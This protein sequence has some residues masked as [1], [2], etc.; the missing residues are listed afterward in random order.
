[1]KILQEIL[2]DI[3]YGLLFYLFFMKTKLN[4]LLNIVLNTRHY[5][6]LAGALF[7]TI[8]YYLILC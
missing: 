8:Q 7:D 6:I 1:M 3:D 4:V 2:S 5:L